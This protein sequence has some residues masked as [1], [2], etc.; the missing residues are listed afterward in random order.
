M[1]RLIRTQTYEDMSRQ[2]ANLLA[3]QVLVKPDCVLGLATGSTPVGAYRQ[4]V[5]RYEA[6]DLDFSHVTSV[7][8]DEYCGI[9]IENQQSYWAFM[10]ENLFDHINMNPSNIHLPNGADTDSAR[11]CARYDGVIAACGGI[12]LQLLGIGRNGHIGFN[13][14]DD[15]FASGTHCV[16]LTEST[17]EANTRFFSS[18][19]EVPRRAYTIGMRAIM[20]A[21]KV[22]LVANGEEKA[23]AVYRS[24]F[25][26]VTP[27]VPASILQL[28]PDV[29]VICDEAAFSKCP[30]LSV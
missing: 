10:H 11:E 22:L 21:K 12:D 14:P 1:I 7:N 6:G 5:A 20:Q 24:F 13:E 9:S 30:K 28:H 26:P 19:E 2:A 18:R 17:I 4:L 15:H 23:E 25:G 27:R 16:E 29:T 3:S 8:L